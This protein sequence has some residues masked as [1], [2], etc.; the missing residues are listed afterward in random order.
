RSAS[1]FAQIGWYGLILLALAIAPLAAFGSTL[2]FTVGPDGYALGISEADA[3]SSG[4]EIVHS[5][6]EIQG[7]NLS[8]TKEIV[9]GSAFKVLPDG[10]GGATE[11]FAVT[12]NAD[13]VGPD[14]T[15]PED[16]LLL[17]FKSFDSA[18][19]DTILGVY[20]HDYLGSFSDPTATP[21]ALTTVGF[22]L[23]PDW[24][25]VS[26]LDDA[27]DQT[28]YFPA[29]TLG[30]LAKGDSTSVPISFW[31]TNPFILPSLDGEG[32]QV[33]L[34]LLLYDAAFVPIP[35]PSSGALLALGLCGLAVRARRRS[36]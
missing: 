6:L 35:E 11:N 29:I 9:P 36:S 34:P 5:P 23:T 18:L 32:V 10:P 21:G 12:Y 24:L 1:T 14:P 26:F 25:L 16:R 17:V 4:L 2:M 22:T 33:G 13:A 8:I 3:L 27:R 19:V 20:A 15:H 30:A 7:E 31:L 28:L